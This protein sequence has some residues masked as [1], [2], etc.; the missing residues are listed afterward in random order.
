[1]ENE[2]FLMKRI[3]E[4]AHLSA[5]REMVMFSDFLNLYEQNLVDERF[6]KQNSV[7]VSFSG[8]YPLSERRVA[9]F[10]P[11]KGMPVNSADTSWLTGSPDQNPKAETCF[12]FA[13]AYPIDCLLIE[14]KSGRFAQPLSHRDYLGAILHLG[15]NRNVT[16]DI[17]I[18][19][20]KA[21]LFCLSR[22]S[23]FIMENLTQV[24]HTSVRVSFTEPKELPSPSFE[25]IRG[26]VASV[27]LDSLISLAFSE[28]RT[29][30]ASMTD[31]GLVFVN[32]RLILSNAF[33]PHEGDIISV[34]H[35]GRMIYDGQTG[36]TK[37]GR[38]SVTVRRYV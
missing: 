30:M 27:R 34:R 35:K 38:I 21:W 3:R 32:G 29:H 10:Y 15:V 24:R 33:E 12:P 6:L 1:M 13:E 22:M 20:Q 23:A 16:G 11:G 17:L 2:E 18:S 14:P 9:A 36:K 37:K 8:G 4:L 19:G 25:T 31:K 26:T 5:K 28:S 7:C